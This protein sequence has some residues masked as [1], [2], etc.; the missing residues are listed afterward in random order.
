M[1]SLAILNVFVCF[2]GIGGRKREVGR[3]VSRDQSW[4]GLMALIKDVILREENEL[5]IACWIVT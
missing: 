2:G 4:N 1:S 5:N 3:D